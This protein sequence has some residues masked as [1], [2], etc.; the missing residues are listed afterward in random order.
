MGYYVSSLTLLQSSKCP[1]GFLCV[2]TGKCAN[3]ARCEGAGGN[4]SMVLLKNTEP[5]HTCPYRL[6]VGPR[7]FCI[8]P[9]FIALNKQITDVNNESKYSRSLSGV[10]K[11]ASQ[12]ESA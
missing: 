1:H 8:C 6:E 2:K 5:L 12:G 4:K 10:R 9:T 7:Q 11:H 3:P